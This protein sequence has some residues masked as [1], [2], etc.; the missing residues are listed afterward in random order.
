MLSWVTFASHL[1][2]FLYR[3]GRVPS[4]RFERSIWPFSTSHGLGRSSPRCL[5]TL[6]KRLFGT[7]SLGQCLHG[8]VFRGR[9]VRA[10]VVGPLKQRQSRRTRWIVLAGLGDET[11]SVGRLYRMFCVLVRA[12]PPSSSGGIRKLRDMHLLCGHLRCVIAF[13]H[14]RRPRTISMCAF[15]EAQS[16]GCNSKANDY[17]VKHFPILIGASFSAWCSAGLVVTEVS[18]FAVIALVRRNATLRVRQTSI[19]KSRN[20]LRRKHRP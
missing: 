15:T 7:D 13:C 20:D 5:V 14:P 1:E 17:I 11:W 10:P 18:T 2:A 8:A 19:S 12:R 9:C 4:H 3:R 6:A 16:M